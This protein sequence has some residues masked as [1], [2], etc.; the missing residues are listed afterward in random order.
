M[1]TG[2]GSELRRNPQVH[3][4]LTSN[5][6]N[7][8]E[9]YCLAKAGGKRVL[10]SVDRASV[11]DHPNQTPV[12]HLHG[13]LDARSEI[14]LRGRLR[15]EDVV[16][17][18]TKLPKE[19]LPDVIFRESEYYETIANPSSFVNHTPQ[20]L[21]RR[22]NAVF[23]GTT[24]EDLN[25]RRW[26]HDGFRERV[27]HRAKY[28]RQLYREPY[29][30]VE[31]EAV[32]TARR[33]FWL[34]TEFESERGDPLRRWRVPQKPVEEVAGGLGV[35][36]VWCKDYVDLQECVRRVGLAG[37]VPAFGREPARFRRSPA[38]NPTVAS[39]IGH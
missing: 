34:R 12:Y 20:S 14:A 5:A 24:L 7:L 18:G 6:D 38:K 22:L 2:E 25:M 35:E 36:V 21:L 33:H 16:W 4:V 26:L 15:C 11:G 19:L 13:F 8:L 9:L 27:D 32:T 10:N 39:E 1:I 31:Y 3:A 30:A 37:N 29:E 17:I 28:L 23:V